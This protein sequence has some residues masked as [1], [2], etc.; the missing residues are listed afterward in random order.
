M[1]EAHRRGLPWSFLPVAATRPHLER[2]GGPG[3]A[4]RAGRRLAGPA[5]RAGGPATTCCTCTPAASCSTPGWC[6]SGSSCTC[7]APTSAPCSTT[8]AG[9]RPSTGRCGRARTSSTPRPTWPSTRLP[10]RPDATYLP[11][12]IDVGRAAGAGAGA[13]AAPV[14]SSPR[15]GSRSRAWTPARDGPAGWSRRSRGRARVVGLDW[16]P[17]AGRRPRRGVELVPTRPHAA[18]LRLAGRRHRRRRAGRRDPVGQRARGDRHRRA[19][20]R[21]RAAAPVRRACAPPVLGDS[22]ESAVEAAVAVVDGS[23]RPDAAAARAW[24]RAHHSPAPRRRPGAPPSTTGWPP[25]DGS[26]PADEGAQRRRGP[27][28]VRQARAR[29][30]TPCAGRC[31]HVIVHTGQHY[32]ERLSEVFFDDLAHPAR[33][34][35][36]S[37]SAPAATA[38]RPAPCSRRWNPCL[39]QH[40]PDWV[41][42]YGDTN[43][44]L[45]GAAGRGEAAPADRAP[46]GRA[47]VVQPADARGAQPGA[48]RPRRRPAA[49]RRPRWRCGHLADEGLA[50]RSRAGRRRDDRRL[51]GDGR[52]GPRPAAGAGRPGVAAG[53]YYVATIH[54]PDN[55]DD[56][57]RLAAIVDGA[58]RARPIR[59]CCWPTRGC[60]AAAEGHGVDAGRGRGRI[61]LPAAA[62][63]RADRAWCCTRRRV[64]TDSGG[65]QKE[66]F[67]LRVPCTTVRTETEWTETVDL[68]WNVLSHRPGRPARPRSAAPAPAPTDATPYGDGHAADRVAD[69]A[70]LSGSAAGLS[71]A[72]A[73]SAARQPGDRGERGVGSGSRR[74]AARARRPAS[75]SG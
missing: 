28:P 18:Y 57:A 27:A 8:R 50:A 36:T 65:L 45:A 4:G 12:P 71:R 51:P 63:P 66:A 62:L 3:P 60:V 52:D 22:P 24:V 15:G 69:V 37:A 6:P 17:A 31:E 70:Q 33:R 38:R 23:L 74:P 7:T 21:A 56:P 72:R 58:G 49:W 16:G 55:T 67:L 68:G 53:E 2:A 59:C 19:R 9:R 73:A 35:S 11:V 30:R 64:V 39:Q 20:R 42:V 40:D 13:R 1:A 75:R 43:S 46:R 32:D 5:G 54:R 25:T 14:V 10:H 29:S 47:A 44:T 41:L 26:E 34:T 61:V 48:H